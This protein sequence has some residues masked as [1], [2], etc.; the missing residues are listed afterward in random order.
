MAI[1][2]R[3]VDFK[4]SPQMSRYWNEGDPVRTHFANAYSVLLPAYE[5]FFIG[6]ISQSRAMLSNPQLKADATAFCRQ[7]GGHAVMHARYN[8]WLVGLGYT[9][10]PGAEKVQEAILG[11]MR[12]FFSMRFLLAI[13]AAGEL[14][15]TAM[16]RQF[17]SEPQ[18]GRHPS[19]PVVYELWKWHALE[20]L[21]H[22]SVCFEIYQSLGG[23]VWM[24]RA[25]LVFIVPQIILFTAFL[26]L[27]FFIKDGL[28]FQRRKLKKQ[29]LAS[30]D[31][32]EF[33][34][35][36]W[37][38]CL[39]YFSSDFHPNQVDDSHLIENTVLKGNN[40]ASL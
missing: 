37:N 26:Q 15:T 18:L 9:F 22:K 20:E 34:S 28:F 30:D 14:V 1:Q 10:A 23:G 5:R 6:L 17:L 29:S 8:Q 39:E 11:F 40:Y 24:R 36:L 2:S 32:E 13:T 19:D 38:E 21:E 16:A 4:F 3:K 12:R 25:A 35:M 27:R 31:R 33:S 7:E